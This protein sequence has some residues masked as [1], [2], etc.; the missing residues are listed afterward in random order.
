[1][2]FRK[3]RGEYKFGKNSFHTPQSTMSQRPLTN[4]SSLK[5]TAAYYTCMVWA[6]YVFTPPLPL[7]P[8]AE[9][10][11]RKLSQLLSLA[12]RANPRYLIMLCGFSCE[13]AGCVH[14]PIHGLRVHDSRL[15]P[16]Q[17]LVRF[18]LAGLA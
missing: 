10:L 9:V 7:D 14:L 2:T 11:V 6:F 15:R 8:D 16:N 18:T 1:M 4:S 3:Q 12:K 13:L 5:I 17:T